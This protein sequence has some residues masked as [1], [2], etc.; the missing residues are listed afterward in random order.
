[1]ITTKTTNSKIASKKVLLLAVTIIAAFIVSLTVDGVSAAAALDQ[2]HASREAYVSVDR[3]WNIISNAADDPKYWSQIH[4]MKIIK[5]EGNTIEADTT[6]GP[7]DA[8]SHVIMTLH[9]KQSVITEFT[10]GPVTG[11]KIMTL[12]PLSENKTKI[13]ALWNIDMPGIPFFGRDF[14]KDNFMKTTEDAL[15]RIA[16]NAV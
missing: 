13:D 16:Q 7:F 8:K 12:S 11:S 9:P 2:I 14:A 1:M 10:Q 15:N 4:T 5:K 3:L 6:V